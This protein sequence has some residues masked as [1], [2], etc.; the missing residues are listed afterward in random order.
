MR[1]NRL[2]VLVLSFFVLL[3]SVAYANVIS[4]GTVDI[5]PQSCPNPLNVKSRGMLPV[6]ILGTP[7]FDITMI[8]PETISLAGASL[9]NWSYEDVATPS[10]ADLCSC[11]AE[12]PDGFLDLTLKFKNEDVV[13]SIGPVS[14][15][16]VKVLTLTGET[17]DGTPIDGIDC[18]YIRYKP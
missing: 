16:D 13:D 6:A 15:G 3:G 12:G 14:D 18:V 17:F 8:D 10:E 7:D 4:Q 5:K 11:T 9:M 2:A 1:V